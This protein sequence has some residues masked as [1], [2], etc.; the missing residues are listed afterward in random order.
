[1]HSLQTQQAAAVAKAALIGLLVAVA[2]E[3]QVELDEITV[4]VAVD[5]VN[6]AAGGYFITHRGVTISGG[7]L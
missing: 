2:T 6:D 4:N 3:Y 7:S 1:M 5:D